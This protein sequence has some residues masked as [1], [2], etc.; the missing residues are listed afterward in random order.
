MI[1]YRLKQLR[2]EKKLY[3]KDIAKLLNISTSAYGFYEQGIREPSNETISFLANLF[4]VSTDYLLGRVDG[5]N[6]KIDKFDELTMWV[7]ELLRPVNDGS[8]K[9]KLVQTLSKLDEKDWQ[10]IEKIFNSMAV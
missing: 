3:Q 6:N 9:Q 4:N 7:G 1:S 5:R 2:E 8:F 10:T